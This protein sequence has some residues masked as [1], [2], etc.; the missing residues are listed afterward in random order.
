MD[1]CELLPSQWEHPPI[2]VVI[3]GA[4]GQLSVS[5]HPAS[6]DIL[7]RRVYHPLPSTSYRIP[8]PAASQI[9]FPTPLSCYRAALPSGAGPS[10]GNT[11]WGRSLHS[12][13]QT[14]AGSQ[15]LRGFGAVVATCLADW[16]TV[17]CWDRRRSG[18]WDS[19]RGAS[20]H[21]R[22]L[23]AVN[24]RSHYYVIV[25]FLCLPW[26]LKEVARETRWQSEISSYDC[27]AVCIFSLSPL[28]QRTYL[29]ENTYVQFSLLNSIKSITSLR[30]ILDIE[31]V[32]VQYIYIYIY[33]YILMHK[34]SIYKV[35]II[36][37][38]GNKMALI[39]GYLIDWLD[40][41]I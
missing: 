34:D 5:T 20:R 7:L 30:D 14:L 6:L 23:F 31:L 26:R 27:H 32:I 21:R 1:I 16:D 22:R 29:D 36:I 38:A 39:H 9:L 19:C 8:C 12:H 15:L 37:R 24:K 11:P 35:T 18:H 10:L 33:I 28:N 25:L 3:S 17:W 13:T 4:F 41:L 2:S 40:W